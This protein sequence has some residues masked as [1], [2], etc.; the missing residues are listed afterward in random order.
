MIKHTGPKSGEASPESP[1][2]TTG[3]FNQ[4]NAVNIA[5][6]DYSGYAPKAP[7]FRLFSGVRPSLEIEIRPSPSLEKSRIIELDQKFKPK[8]E[9]IKF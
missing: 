8:I 4:E 6:G 5:S 3:N 1:V 9:F 2:K 7:A